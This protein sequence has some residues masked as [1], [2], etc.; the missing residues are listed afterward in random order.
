MWIASVIRY[1]WRS[2]LGFILSE[3]KSTRAPSK[4]LA[5][6]CDFRAMRTEAKG[7]HY[8]VAAIFRLYNVDVR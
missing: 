3:R 7:I 4:A 1:C 6:C 2:L 5:T 8:R